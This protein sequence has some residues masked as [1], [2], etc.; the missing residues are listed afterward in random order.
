[1]EGEE[2]REEMEED[3]RCFTMV[4]DGDVSII[5]AVIGVGVRAEHEET[6]GYWFGLGATG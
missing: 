2:G 4:F 1:M 5:I 6:D 3:W